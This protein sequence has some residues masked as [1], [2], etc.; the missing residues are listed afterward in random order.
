[1]VAI[2]NHRERSWSAINRIFHDRSE[3]DIKN[4]CYSRL[5]Y[6]N[7][8]D[9]IRWVLSRNLLFHV[10]WIERILANRSLNVI[11]WVVR[12]RLWTR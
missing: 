4:R 7:S 8:F 9:W 1:L 2:V 5:Q 10:R 3:N 12:D 6:E 11:L